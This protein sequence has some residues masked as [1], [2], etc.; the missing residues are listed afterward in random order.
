MGTFCWPQET[1]NRGTACKSRDERN[2]KSGKRGETIRLI[3]FFISELKIE[4]SSNL[5]LGIKML[6]R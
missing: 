2:L 4:I 1:T 3:F 6:L 5:L